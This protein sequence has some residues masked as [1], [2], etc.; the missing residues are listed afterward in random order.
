MAN[1]RLRHSKEE[2]GSLRPMSCGQLHSKSREIRAVT[3]EV[4]KR[5]RR[6]DWRQEKAFRRQVVKVVWLRRN[7]ATGTNM[8][9]F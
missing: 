2:V 3:Q 7:Y 5:V 9:S 8:K 6:R 1:R 4:T